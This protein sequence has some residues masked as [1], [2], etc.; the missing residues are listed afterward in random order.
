MTGH[1]KHEKDINIPLRMRFYPGI[2]KPKDI[3]PRT[4]PYELDIL[5]EGRLREE[6]MTKL[7]FEGQRG[8]GWHNGEATALR[9]REQDELCAPNDSDAHIL[10]TSIC[11]ASG[12]PLTLST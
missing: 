7:D 6:E 9:E 4:K 2:Q 8:W 5:S 1:K 10:P 12:A 11:T 3:Q